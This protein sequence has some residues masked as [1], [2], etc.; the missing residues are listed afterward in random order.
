MRPDDEKPRDASH[1]DYVLERVQDLFVDDV[2]QDDGSL[3][4]GEDHHHTRDLVLGNIDMLLS[5]YDYYVR[6][7]AH[8][9][10]PRDK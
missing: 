9:E 7:G 4:H 8:T 3:K 2:K 1:W 10:T 5:V 6:L